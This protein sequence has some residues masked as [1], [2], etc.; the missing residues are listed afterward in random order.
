MDTNANVEEGS[1]EKNNSTTKDVAIQTKAAE[2]PK[3]WI[4]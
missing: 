4:V 3:G 1:S 2:K